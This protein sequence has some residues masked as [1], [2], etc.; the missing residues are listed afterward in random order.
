MNDSVTIGRAELRKVSPVQGWRWI[1]AGFRLFAK[2]PLIWMVFFLIYFFVQLV[3]VFK[4]P[5]IGPVAA[6]LLDPFF[7]AGFMAGCRALELDEDMEIAHLL[8]G[9]RTDA[10]QLAKLGGLYL[11]GKMAIIVIAMALTNAL[12]GPMPEFDFAH[13]DFAKPDLPPAV[14]QHIQLTGLLVLAFMVPLLMAY[15]FAP[16]L[17]IFDHLPAGHS[18]RLSFVACRRNIWPFLLYGAV[19]LFLFVL[20]SIP[21]GLGLLVVVPVLFATSIYAAYRDIFVAQTPPG[22]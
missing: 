20:A 7:I 15:W 21:F 2:T 9:F 6:A 22:S 5:V 14:A 18:M 4:V 16:A 10:A 11:A 1:A 17:V 12:L 19:S 3:L 13:L 8:A